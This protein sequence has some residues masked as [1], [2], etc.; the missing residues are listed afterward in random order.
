MTARRSLI[1]AILILPLMSCTA[2]KV[3][4][5]VLNGH[6]VDA[7]R[8]TDGIIYALP[9]KVIAVR[10]EQTSVSHVAGPLWHVRHFAPDI[11]FADSPGATS[12]TYGK[13]S[14]EAYATPDPDQVF[15]V[16]ALGGPQKDSELLVEL[17]ESGVIMTGEA[18][19]VDK[20]VEFAVRFIEAG[21]RAFATASSIPAPVAS[22]F[23]A[24]TRPSTTTRTASSD[25]ERAAEAINRAFVELEEARAHLLDNKDASMSAAT[26][27]K[28][29]N[30]ID[31]VQRQLVSRFLK[32]QIKTAVLYDE[33]VPGEDKQ[34]KSLFGGQGAFEVHFDFV[35]GDANRIRAIAGALD[36]DPTDSAR[37]LERGLYYR[38]P[39]ACVVRVTK[40]GAEQER[41]RVQVPQLGAIAA[42]PAGVNSTDVRIIAN[43]YQDTGGLSKA[44]V[45]SKSIDPELVDRLSNAANSLAQVEAAR[46]AAEAAKPGKLD[47]LM[48]DLERAKKLAEL[49]GFDDAATAAAGALLP[50][51]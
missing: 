25:D 13:P 50:V 30:E 7:P 42:L 5:L 4:P 18:A 32:V 16:R 31:T 29:L 48:A 2:A 14:I 3:R 9:K 27:E 22:S 39:A 35:G 33:Y 21:A 10:V 19:V 12:V 45:K 8:K 26:L 41:L 15:L 6:T 47:K 49:F 44:G 23:R 17:T 36:I 20:T 40:S 34:S 24:T 37:S 11:Q 38:I 51:P 28:M 46:R 1:A 43:Y